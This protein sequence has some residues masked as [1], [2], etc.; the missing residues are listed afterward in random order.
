MKTET[1]EKSFKIGA[2]WKRIVFKTLRFG[3]DKWKGW[4]RNLRMWLVPILNVASGQGGR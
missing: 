1:F 2:F 4:R 3:V